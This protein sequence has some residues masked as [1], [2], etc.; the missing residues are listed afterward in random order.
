MKRSRF[1]DEQIIAI[2]KEQEAG[3]PTAEVC[4]RHGISPATFY[5]WKAKYGGLEVS[6]AK[7][8]RSLEDENAKLKK[9]LAEA[10]LDIPVLSFAEGAVLKDITAKSGDARSKAGSGG[11]CSVSVR[12]ER[13]PGVR[14]YRR[15]PAR[16]QLCVTAA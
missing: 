13:A 12:A 10:M 6:E 14:H 4:R 9:L 3:M 15:V 7:R 2:L 16:E 11:S 1:S 8:L 5:K